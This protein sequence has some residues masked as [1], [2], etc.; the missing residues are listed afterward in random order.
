MDAPPDKEDC[1]PFVKVAGL[2]AAAGLKVPR[3]LAW[4]E[5]Q[6]FML[7]DDLGMQTMIEVLDRDNAVANLP[8]YMRA[9]DALVSWQAAS[10]PGVLPEY[11]R[12][13][14]LR[15]LSLFPDWYLE[16]HRGVKVEGSN[17][18]ACSIFSKK[19][20]SA[21]TA[22]FVAMLARIDFSIISFIY[23]IL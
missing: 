2:M 14:L 4:D 21:K 5:P 7:L 10:R 16:R 6:G 3:I 19:P 20:A 8:L 17:W 15:E 12:A 9:A 18:A 13:L 23:L 22:C 11:D 1:Q